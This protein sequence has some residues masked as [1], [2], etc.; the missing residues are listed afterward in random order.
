MKGLFHPIFTVIVVSL[1]TMKTANS[2]EKPPNVKYVDPSDFPAY[3]MFN[4][5]IEMEHKYNNPVLAK[6]KYLKA[7]KMKP[8]MEEAM[9]NLGTLLEKEG[10]RDGAVGMFMR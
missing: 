4:D 10:D 1:F 7:L 5:A 3:E 2:S 6:E 8:D 9:I